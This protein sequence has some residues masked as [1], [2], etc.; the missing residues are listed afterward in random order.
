MTSSLLDRITRGEYSAGIS[1]ILETTQQ[2]EG[3]HNNEES[4][5]HTTGKILA[6]SAVD[7]DGMVPRRSINQRITFE[8][9]HCLLTYDRGNYAKSSSIPR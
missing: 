8:R 7:P 5:V 9:S 3:K 4:D 2:G 1:E 6:G